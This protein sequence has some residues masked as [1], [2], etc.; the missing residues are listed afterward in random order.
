[1]QDNDIEKLM[2]RYFDAL[3]S[4]APAPPTLEE[5]RELDE[6]WWEK[7]RPQFTFAQQL[8]V[9]EGLGKELGLRQQV[10][11]EGEIPAVLLDKDA[12]LQ[13]KTTARMVMCEFENTRLR[14]G[15]ALDQPLL[16]AESAE[17]TICGADGTVLLDAYVQMT[18]PNEIVVDQ[19]VSEEETAFSRQLHSRTGPPIYALIKVDQPAGDHSTGEGRE[20][21][22]LGVWFESQV[23]KLGAGIVSKVR[24]MDQNQSRRKQRVG[25]NCLLPGPLLD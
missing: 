25:A 3:A 15:L 13:T 21:L 12:N 2:K 17:V 8:A 14:L 23:C 20:S 24:A 16:G 11:H 4:L 6:P 1:M 18:V 7:F 10:S 9:A 5:L 19:H 22:P